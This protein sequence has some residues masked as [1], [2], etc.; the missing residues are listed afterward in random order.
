MTA[1]ATAKLGA[2][3]CKKKKGSQKGILFCR[4][5]AVPDSKIIN[6]PLKWECKRKKTKFYGRCFDF[7]LP[8]VRTALVNDTL[9]T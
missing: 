1:K 9:C 8:G 4:T 6:E 2:I 3:T 5:T 7:V